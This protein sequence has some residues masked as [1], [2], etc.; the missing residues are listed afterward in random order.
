MSVRGY[1]TA[2]RYMNLLL[3]YLL[4]PFRSYIVLPDIQT[5]KHINRQTDTT[6][7]N[8]TL[9][10]QVVLTYVSIV[11]KSLILNVKNMSS[12]QLN[13]PIIKSYSGVEETIPDSS[14]PRVDDCGM[15]NFTTS[16]PFT[17]H[18]RR[19]TVDWQHSLSV[20]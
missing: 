2:T 10:A 9:A 16:I 17:N 14:M 11:I 15:L 8:T 20:C 4:K 18:T 5:D 1:F 3:T 6:E 13:L 7:S 12:E 19:H